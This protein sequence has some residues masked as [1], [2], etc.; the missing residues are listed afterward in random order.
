M[1]IEEFRRKSIDN[2]KKWPHWII[3][4]W[5]YGEIKCWEWYIETNV[6]DRIPIKARI[7][8]EGKRKERVL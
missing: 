1:D 3:S 2:I 7:K 4:L 6:D 8:E 5:E